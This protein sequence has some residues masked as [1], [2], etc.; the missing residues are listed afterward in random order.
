VS[1]HDDEQDRR[2]YFRIED[3]AHVVVHEVP[4]EEYAQM[5]EAGEPPGSEECGLVAELN[6][7]SSQAGILMSKLRKSDPDVAHYLGLLDRKIDLV[8][9]MCESGRQ[10]GL[11]PNARINLS[12]NGVGLRRAEPIAEGT[13]VEVRLVFF[14]SYLCVHAYG[15]VAHCREAEDADAGHPYEVGV[16]LTV[17]REMEREALIKHT[18]ERQ[19]ALLRQQRGRE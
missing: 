3:D 4:E 14:P 19:S 5:L 6:H 2:Q 10:E 17:M 16:E 12:A 15:E 1:P 7:L 8:A 9:R 11:K 18:L 13:K